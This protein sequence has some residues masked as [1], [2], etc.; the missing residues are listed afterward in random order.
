MDNNNEMKFTF[1]SK[2]LKRR[3]ALLEEKRKITKRELAELEKLLGDTEKNKEVSINKRKNT[4]K[5]ID[6]LIDL[7]TLMDEGL[8]LKKKKLAKYLTK[9]Y[10]NN[11]TYKKIYKKYRNKNLLDNDLDE[12]DKKD[13]E[14][15]MQKMAA[16]E[17]NTAVGMSLALEMENKSDKKETTAERIGK[18]KKSRKRKNKPPTNSSLTEE[19][20]IQK[21]LKENFNSATSLLKNTIK[22]TDMTII[23]VDEEIQILKKNKRASNRVRDLSLLL[24]VK[25][26]L[27]T[28]RV[29]S[30]KEMS[31]ISKNIMDASY[32]RIKDTKSTNMENVSDAE[33]FTNFFN[34]TISGKV[35]KSKKK[36]GGKKS[37]RDKSLDDAFKSKDLELNDYDRI[38]KYEGSWLPAIKADYEERDWKFVAVG[39]D[40]NII[41]KFPSNLLPKKKNSQIDF[42]DDDKARDKKTGYI[43]NVIKVKYI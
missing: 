5:D 3:E 34:N 42:L 20:K 16:T 35:E 9:F 30:S 15:L 36:K 27:L 6:N 23:D 18:Y 2:I 12:W 22:E 11:K 24:G 28:L 7:I 33:L 13:L 19:R 4:L 1:N 8:E 38:I 40:G 29:N 39:D 32:K 10:K 25:K 26:D 14:K 17:I 43:Y 37:K 21:E 31:S 41:K